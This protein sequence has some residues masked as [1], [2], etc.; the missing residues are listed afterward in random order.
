MI[1]TGN[2]FR[3]VVRQLVVI[4]SPVVVYYSRNKIFFI[5][6]PLLFQFS[7]KTFP[8]RFKVSLFSEPFH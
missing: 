8:F 1:R 5:R 4:R 2:G 3:T 6:R 7:T